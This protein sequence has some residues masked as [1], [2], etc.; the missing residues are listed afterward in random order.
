MCPGRFVTALVLPSPDAAHR[1]PS[2]SLSLRI[3]VPQTTHHRALQV[4]PGYRDCRARGFWKCLG[5]AGSSAE[6]H[7]AYASVT[8]DI[9]RV[10]KFRK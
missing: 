1:G 2:N 9:P 5:C 10:L 3:S 7:V 4:K 6:W 8:E